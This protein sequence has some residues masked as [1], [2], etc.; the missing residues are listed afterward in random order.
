MQTIK[1]YKIIND[2]DRKASIIF[3]ESVFYKIKKKIV[4]F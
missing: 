1:E 2:N 3:E 4:S